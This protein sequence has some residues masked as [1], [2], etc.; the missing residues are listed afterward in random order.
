MRLIVED[1]VSDRYGLAADEVLALRTGSNASPA[2]L[3]LYTYRSH[4]ALVGR[5]QNVHHELHLDYCRDHGLAVNRRPTGGGA[6]IMG[7]QQLGIALAVPG[8]KEARYGNARAL[9]ESFSGGILTGLATFGIEALFSRKN[10]LE[11]SGR[12][13]AGLGIHRT[14]TGG[15]L[16]HCSLLVDLDVADPAAVN[17]QPCRDRAE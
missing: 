15:L 1:G 12:K 8:G 9:M 17:I 14:S 2:T 6:I 7:E 4:T 3:R 5:F 16:F 13:I 11:V 10:D